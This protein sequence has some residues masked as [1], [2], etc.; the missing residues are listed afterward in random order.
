MKNFQK[1]INYTFQNPDLLK[2]AFLHRSY[3]NEHKDV[4]LPHNERLE[5]LGDAVLELVVTDWLF[6]EYP[7]KPEGELTSYRAALVNANTCSTVASEIG[8]NE[9]LLLS[10]GEARDTGR[11]RQIILANVY[12][13][14]V[15]AIYLDGGYESARKFI[16]ETIFPKADEMIK[17]NITE[18]YKSYFQRKA[19]EVESITPAYRVLSETGPDHDKHFVVGLYLNKEKVAEGSGHSKQE[20]EQD[21][22]RR[23]LEEKGWLVL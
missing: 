9:L 16:A 11:A 18:D 10:R 15:G 17:K 20:A 21:A 14:I 5:F 4:T 19:Q 22:A 12:E 7:D 8:A 1:K 6:R 13:A 3:L 23:G 2:Q